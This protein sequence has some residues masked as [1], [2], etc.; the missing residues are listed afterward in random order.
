MKKVK[1]RS[2]WYGRALM[3]IGV[4][5]LI[6]LLAG[7]EEASPA[8]DVTPPAD[9]GGG[10]DTDPLAEADGSWLVVTIG[11]TPVDL[12]QGLDVGLAE[13]GGS[14]TTTLTVANA[15]DV[16]VSLTGAADDGGTLGV[17]VGGT[18]AA[19]FSID[20]SNVPESLEA[21]ASVDVGLTFSPTGEAGDRTATIT[22]RSNADSSA[23]SLPITGEAGEALISLAETDGETT[24]PLADGG[25]IDWGNVL[26][27][28]GV[29]QRTISITND[30]SFAL[31]ISAATLETVIEVSGAVVTD[32]NPDDDLNEFFFVSGPDVSAIDP[33]STRDFLLG[34][35]YDD[36]DWSTIAEG[37]DANGTLTLTSNAA[38]DGMGEVV[39]SLTATLGY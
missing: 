11:A 30:G 37:G 8:G 3:A 36:T 35:E 4:I 18:D 26:W 33:G 13:L 15:S 10:G 21:G 25:T 2:A 14:E 5:V 9:D 28:T 24:T 16:T 27:E 29:Q 20:A 17:A 23:Y 19:E 6:A 12:T 7:C 34:I 39:I 38:G 22:A 31:T 1:R 32:P